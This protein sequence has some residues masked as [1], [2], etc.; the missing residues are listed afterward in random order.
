MR[1]SLNPT[2]SIYKNKSNYSKESTHKNSTLPVK[3][4][5]LP[6]YKQVYTN[7]IKQISFGS[8]K[9]AELFKEIASLMAQKTSLMAQIAEKEMR[10]KQTLEAIA[11]KSKFINAQVLNDAEK[12]MPSPASSLNKRIAGYFR[13]KEE[14]SCKFVQRL[15]KSKNDPSIEVPSCIMLHGP[16]CTGKTS[17]VEGIKEQTQGFAE[18]INISNMLGN[19]GFESRLKRVLEEAKDRYTKEG[20]RTILLMDQPERILSINTSDASILGIKLDDFDKS[21]LDSYGNNANTISMFK[22]L[23]DDVSKIP[24][25]G[26]SKISNKS[27]VTFLMTT[28]RPHLIHPDLTSRHGKI[29]PISIGL[30]SDFNIG[31]VL[32]FYFKK[33]N[34]VADNLKK[35]KP[36]PYYQYKIDGLVEITGKVKENLK[37]MIKDGTIDNLHVDYNNMPYAQIIA[38]LN[39]N[40]SEGAYNNVGLR[41][42]VRNAFNDYLEKNP[43][44]SDYKDSFFKVLVNTKRDISPERYQKYLEIQKRFVDEEVDP[45]SLN[46]LIRQKQFGILSDKT[47]KLLEDHIE[48]IKSELKII[49]EQ[50]ELGSLNES[51]LAR[52]KELEELLLVIS[53]SEQDL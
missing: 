49:S 9:D 40:K 15:I 30:A 51:Q 46:Q 47:K 3:G 12:T 35:S 34:D 14:I 22:S 2:L 32:K 52:K 23:L 36:Y 29:T 31:E 18:V 19:Q 25:E 6:G 45:D 43:A 7:N 10:L 38:N 5:Q 44:E 53:K 50:A 1:L 8:V 4:M 48:K 41:E 42:I 26:D 24:H 13:E 39:P 20:K 33:M 16:I 11:L 21:M 37:K 28:S 17:F 27:A